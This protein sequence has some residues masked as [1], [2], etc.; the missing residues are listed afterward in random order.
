MR[1]GIVACLAATTAAGTTINYL[2]ADE[3]DLDYAVGTLS[4]V[5]KHARCDEV[6]AVLNLF[7][8]GLL[9]EKIREPTARDAFIYAGYILM[10]E[11]RSLTLGHM[12]SAPLRFCMENPSKPLADG[13]K[14]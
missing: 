2:H 11:G 13:F 9:G 7:G 5:Q 4:H 12:D 1:L 6:V 14:Q 10:M 3:V 8:K